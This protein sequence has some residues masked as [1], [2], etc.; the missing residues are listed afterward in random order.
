MAV[1]PFLFPL[2]NV[3]PVS[4]DEFFLTESVFSHVPVGWKGRL[5]LD[6]DVQLRQ[7]EMQ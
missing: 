1:L 6:G 4:T 5:S 3:A 2:L 7:Q